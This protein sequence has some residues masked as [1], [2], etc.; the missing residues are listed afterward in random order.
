M[1][2]GDIFKYI[3]KEHKGWSYDACDDASGIYRV[4]DAYDYPRKIT[5]ELVRGNSD[6]F[7]LDFYNVDWQLGDTIVLEQE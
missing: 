6:F 1:N 3:D 5:A 4:I 7:R 2:I